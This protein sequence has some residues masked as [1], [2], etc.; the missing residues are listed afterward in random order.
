VLRARELLGGSTREAVAQARA[1]YRRAIELDP[2]Y[3]VPP[4]SDINARR[5]MGPLLRLGPDVTTHLCKN[6]AVHH[7]KNCALMS[8]MGDKRTMDL[9]V[10]APG[11]PLYKAD[12]AQVIPAASSLRTRSLRPRASRHSRASACDP[13]DDRRPTSTSTVFR[14]AADNNSIGQHVVIVIVPLS[15]GT[16]RRCPF[17]D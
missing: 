5:L 2:A 9:R 15:G 6:A 3:A 1:M 17:E 7:S 4:S 16:A 10:A 11:C 14:Q 8:Q 12:I 13:R